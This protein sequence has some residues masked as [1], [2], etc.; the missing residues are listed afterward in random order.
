MDNDGGN[1]KQLTSGNLDWN[2]DISADG[3]WVVYVS[4]RSGKE[5]LWRVPINGGEPTQLTQKHGVAPS[6]SPDGKLV[7]FQ[8]YDDQAYKT[9]VA[10]MPFEGGE[11]TKILDISPART[12][13]GGPTSLCWAPDGQAITYVDT[14]NGVSNIWSQPLSVGPPKQLTHFNSD[15]IFWFAQS[16]DG[17]QLALS[18]GNQ[19]SDVVLI[20]NFR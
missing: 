14:R 10:I 16:R 17:K 1:L 11:P 9:R 18:R 2:P 7:A 3:K 5:T 15:Q 12:P 6:I 20:S 4:S 19:T 8:S 13:L